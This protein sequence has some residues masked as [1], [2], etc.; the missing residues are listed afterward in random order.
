VPDLPTTPREVYE[1]LPLD[2]LLAIDHRPLQRLLVAR[3][4]WESARGATAQADRELAEAAPWRT[5]GCALGISRQAAQQ[6]FGVPAPRDD[7]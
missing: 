1:R 4:A 3:E 7:H 6:R 2:A 5:I